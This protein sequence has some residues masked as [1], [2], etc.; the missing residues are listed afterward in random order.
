M[1]GH[2]IVCAWKYNKKY[3][4]L[5]LKI[6]KIKIMFHLQTYLIW[7]IANNINILLYDIFF[8]IVSYLL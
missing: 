4:I 7:C 3:H 8:N 2:N 5:E 6:D 1:I